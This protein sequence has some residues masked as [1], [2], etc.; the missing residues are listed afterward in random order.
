M[1][2]RTPDKTGSERTTLTWGLTK[3]HKAE[4]SVLADMNRRTLNNWLVWT[5]KA[6]TSAT[7]Q[8]RTVFLSD[9]EIDEKLRQP[10]TI[11]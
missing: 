10:P 11:A 2:T 4:M 7:L 9:A 5:T 8:R 3:R 1:T 6:Y